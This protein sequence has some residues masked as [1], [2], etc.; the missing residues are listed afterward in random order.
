MR[1][2][3][4]VR[5]INPTGRLTERET[6]RRKAEALFGVLTSLYGQERLGK[7]VERVGARAMMSS[8]QLGRRVLA[9]QR[10]VFDDANMSTVPR[11]AEIP[12]VLEDLQERIADLMARKSI[13][14]EIERRVQDRMKE[15]QEEYLRAIRMQV[16]QDSLGPETESTRRKLEELHQLEQVRL[17]RTALEALRPRRLAHVVGQTRAIRSLLTKLA[18]PIPQHVILYG[19]PGV[20]KTTVA[21]L[22]LEE[23][24][25]LR[26]SP[27]QQ[28]APFIEVDASTLRWDSREATN[29]LLGS[30]HDPIYQ[31]SR[32]EFAEQG[33]P[34]P[35]LG[36]VTRAHGGVL[37]IDEIGEF[38][39][40]LQSK[41]L[42][43]LEDKRVHFESSYYDAANPQLP[44]YVKRLFE[45]GAPADFILIGATTKEPEEISPTLRSRCAE[46]FFDPLSQEDIDKI[47]R[48]AARRLTVELERGVSETISE[49]TVEGRKA[50]NLLAD[51]YGVA[52][53]RRRGRGH[54]RITRHDLVE[55]IRSGRLAS[56]TPTKASD[57]PEVGKV[58]ALGVTQYVGSLIEIEATAFAV[59]K[60]QRGSIRF[61]ETAGTMA[62]DSVFNAASVIRKVAGIDVGNYDVHVNV[63]G[64]GLIDGPSA[65]LAV[66]LAMLSAIQKKPVRQDVA[67]TGEVSIQGKVKQVGGIPEKIYGARQAG[68]RKV[69]IPD[70]NRN[71]VP[72]DVRGIDVVSA[73]N[74]EDVLSHVFAVK[75]RSNGRK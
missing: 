57:V 63:I 60:R 11:E 37:F 7:R 18:V 72:S 30:V 13:E 70:E 55:V 26:Q 27:F 12:A 46:V 71:E 66:V 22:A 62:K 2:V 75:R 49:Y 5:Q 59:G 4:T 33:I 28:Q 53:Y 61:N 14:D 65:G 41:L 56:T 3:K 17:A 67:V 36:L 32:R 35:K 31:G 74:I 29:P 16:M 47:V 64:G 39:A 40:V 9:L 1:Q 48:Q 6:L 42:K 21:R 44:G 73:G 24:K 8:P 43:V 20:G 69:I 51:A 34:E 54:P 19:P 68:M 58:F 52:L 50:V 10:L 25:R 15:R 45:Q 38:D 23:A